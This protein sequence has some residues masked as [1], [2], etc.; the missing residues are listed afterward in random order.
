ME[1]IAG[2]QAVHTSEK[3]TGRGFGQNLAGRFGQLG[4]TSGRTRCDGK[5]CN[6]GLL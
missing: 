1:C 5:A 3:R 4:Q 6:K 2:A